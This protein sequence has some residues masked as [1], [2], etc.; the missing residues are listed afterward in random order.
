MKNA[1]L[2]F[3][4]R[5]L[6]RIIF[7]AFMIAALLSGAIPPPMLIR[8]APAPLERAAETVA[9]LL[10][11]PSVAH[12]AAF[13]YEETPGLG[14]PDGNC[15]DF[16]TNV[17]DDFTIDDLNLGLTISHAFRRDVQ[18]QL[19][20]PNGTQVLLFTN[21]GGNGDHLD[22]LLDDEAGTDIGLLT[23][24]PGSSH[25]IGTSFYENAFNLEGAPVLSAFDTE[26][27]QGDWILT[28][29]DN[30]AQIVGTLERVLLQFDGT[31]SIAPGE[32]K[33][34]A[35]KDINRNGSNDNEQGLAGVD[36]NVID[37]NGTT[38]STTT[39]ADGSYLIAA[40][41]GLS[42]EVRVEFTLP[43]NGSL[44]SYEP[45]IAGPSTVQFVNVATGASGID[46][47]Y[48]RPLAMFC[49]SAVA[50][51]VVS[52]FSNGDPTHSS[53]SSE[54]A[55]AKFDYLTS[56]IIQ[57]TDPSNSYA[58]SASIGGANGV[59]NVW[60]LAY[61]HHSGK[62]YSSAVVKRHTGATS[63]GIGAIYVQTDVTNPNSASLFFNFGASVGTIDSNATRF[64]G[65]GSAFGQEG[66]CRACDNIDPTTFARPGT[67]G[68]G[69]ID[70][71][72]DGTTL[73]TVNLDDRKLYSINTS[74]TAAA[75][76]VAGAPWVDNS[77][78]TNGVARPWAVNEYEGDVYVGV[79][80]DASSSSCGISNACSD[81]TA[82]IY[83]YDVAA[84]TWSTAMPSTALTYPRTLY[85]NGQ[86]TIT[87]FQGAACTG[88]GAGA[89]WHP[90]VND[91]STISA[92]IQGNNRIDP[93]YPQPILSNIEFADDGHMI[94]ALGDRSGLQFGYQAP[95]P[96]D[97]NAGTTSVYYFTGGD[98]VRATYDTGSSQYQL[99]ANV[100]FYNDS[101][102]VSS[103]PIATDAGTGAISA[104]PGASSVINGESDALDAFS[105]GTLFMSTETG[106]Y[107]AAQEVYDTGGS[108]PLTG[109]G[110]AKSGG[111]GDI[112]MIC[113]LTTVPI[114]VGNRVWGDTDGDGLQDPGEAGI[115]GIGVTLSCTGPT[116]SDTTTT[117]GDGNYLFTNVP[118]GATCTISVDTTQGLI[119]S[120]NLSPTDAD[121][122][123]DNGN[124]N[125]LRDS[126]A[127]TSGNNAQVAFTVGTAGQNNHTFD[128]GFTAVMA[129]EKVAIGNM[130]WE[131]LN[132][133]GI[134]NSGIGESGIDG[135]E[136]Q[137]FQ[138]TTVTGSPFM[139]DTTTGGGFYLFDELDEGDYVVH[140]P[141]SEFAA[142]G[143]LDGYLSSDPEGT[144]NTSDDNADENGQNTLDDNG[145]SST[146]IDLQASDEPTSEAGQGTYTGSLNDENVNLTVD[147]GFYSLSLGNL[148]FNDKFNNGTYEPADDNGL[149]GVVV[150]LHQGTSVS[151]SPLMTTT[152]SGGGLYLFSGLQPGEYV[153]ELDSSNWDPGAVLAKFLSSLTDP[154]LLTDAAPDPDD[155]VNDD[156]NGVQQF[157]PPR[158][159]VSAPVTLS[160]PNEPDNDGDSD[161]N[162]NLSVDF[163]LYDPD[164]GD[165]VFC[166]VNNNGMFDAGTADYGIPGVLLNLYTD[167]GG[168]VGALDATDTQVRTTTTITDGKYIFAFLPPDEYIVEVDPSNF[169]ADQIL[170]GAISVVG[171]TDPDDDINNDDNGEPASGFGTVA[172]PVTITS[173]GEP[174]NDGDASEFTNLAIDFGFLQCTDTPSIAVDKQLNT[175]PGDPSFTVGETIS[176][177]IRITNTGNLTITTLPLEDRYSHAFL[178][179]QSAVPAHTTATDGI[180]TWTDL[181][182]NDGDGLGIDEAVSVDVFFTT[183]ADTTLLPA[184][185]PCTSSGHAPNLARSVGATAGATSV[186]QDADDT[187]CDSVQILNPTGILLRERSISQTPDGVLVRWSTVSEMDVVGFHI[188]QVNGVNTQKISSEMIVAKKAGISS[189]TNYSWVDENVILRRGDVY[190]LEIINN[191]GST[192]QIVIGV[193]MGESIFLPLVAK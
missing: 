70:V 46:V 117:T 19:E 188:W 157:G 119:S 79:V 7:T 106:A 136:V 27:A 31:P 129:A 2:L 114:Q 95:S 104:L 14:I 102:Q 175:T 82:H 92:V 28:V 49:D 44:D 121:A 110:F 139:T 123:S 6:G 80:C 143:P 180:V 130:V 122:Q 43:T 191:D 164:I 11:E 176:F 41:A 112:E 93:Q 50:E 147:F 5:P 187:S 105:A 42:G 20:S 142:N 88:S 162:S 77:D 3:S 100:D 9:A 115:N 144:D 94:L 124:Q 189:G 81:L 170:E 76:E 57:T 171:A 15:M 193:M 37:A 73:Y 63:D 62:L 190:G 61:D 98:T 53:N 101:W 48:H 155:D 71:S 40:S 24:G 153:V 47:G 8:V 23:G 179:Y 158:S 16:T 118:T 138:G 96:T 173:G 78:C 156:D 108:L 75:S 128:I 72:E 120:L 161:K 107:F 60:G 25:T 4:V 116:H 103:T 55:I 54:T 58:Q 34:T 145:I 113:P 148:V 132:N 66:P 192:E 69:D 45:T 184:V 12:A 84:S 18:A 137:L 150:N 22:I 154:V 125:D 33:G 140:I 17:P 52:C 83:A 86:G 99:D 181:L 183:A 10:P 109:D 89:F 30:A 59:G 151:G 87:T 13:S 172:L 160:A 165:L 182:A 163:G 152:T 35:Y 186:I 159:V 74:G 177:T 90:W 169:T 166:D 51:Y 36:V 38:A 85:C 65:S 174:T 32:V 135:V 167:D 134:F 133:N 67:A 149:D 178:T 97:A 126:D 68:L 91:Y 168:T 26:N 56:G 39:G 185:A 21:V 141:A 64:P 29:C 146:S 131:D 1:P 111:T 127:S